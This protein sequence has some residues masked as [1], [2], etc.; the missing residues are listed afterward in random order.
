MPAPALIV[1]FHHVL[2]DGMGGLAVLASL[3]DG[4]VSPRPRS[5]PQ[6][7][8]S[9]RRL[10]LDAAASRVNAFTHLSRVPARTRDAFAELRP[11]VTSRASR[12][13]LNR[14][15]GPRRRFS[16]VHADLAQVRSV[17]HTYGGTV[18]D[19]VLAAVSGA[20]HAL[21][22][23]RG[24]RVGQLVA[25]VPVSGRTEATVAQLGNQIG[26]IP[27]MLPTSGG[28]F[29]RLKMI[30]EIT[31]RHKTETRGA[32]AVLLAP[33][34]R[35]LAALG[36]LRWL[37]ER[38]HLVT[39]FV[40]NLRGPH[41]S[42]SFLGTPVCEV[43]PLNTV[44]GNLAGR[45]RRPVLCGHPHGDRHCRRRHIPRLRSPRRRPS[46]RRLDVLTHRI[47]M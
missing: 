28:P 9:W 26:V 22:A 38:Q 45:V 6:P 31:R 20:L 11:G 32:S 8:P 24:E 42:V 7:K 17:G 43:V 4:V 44:T 5:F 12:C 18:N 33:A 29:D 13:S 35:A 25:S 40:T 27:V 30:A 36:V 1:V 39:T 46:G 21:L 16:V 14:P 15:V 3:V 2:A 19:V 10:A 34:S 23:H 41:A 37:A 47:G